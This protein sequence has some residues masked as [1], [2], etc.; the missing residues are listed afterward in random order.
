MP[1]DDDNLNMSTPGVFQRVMLITHGMLMG[2]LAVN[3]ALTDAEVFTILAPL[4]NGTG[5]TS[6]L[7]K[8]DLDF[9]RSNVLEC[10]AV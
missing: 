6:E 10:F 5:L 4:L 1:P 9:A 3:P 2:A 7:L 8:D